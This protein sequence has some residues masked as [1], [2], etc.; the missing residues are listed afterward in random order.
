[1]RTPR[2]QS[3]RYS[4][5]EVMF[6]LSKKNLPSGVINDNLN[7]CLYSVSDKGFSLLVGKR[8]SMRGSKIKETIFD[9][10]M[11]NFVAKILAQT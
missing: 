10:K 4:V 6:P 5:E 11:Q 8:M 2:F 3:A 7:V 1:M 9:Y